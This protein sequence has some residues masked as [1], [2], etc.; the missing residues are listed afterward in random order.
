VS[1]SPSDHVPRA[2]L[3][4]LEQE[5][6]LDIEHIARTEGCSGK[7]AAERYLARRRAARG[8]RE[9]VEVTR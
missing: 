9:G 3:A 4:A 6:A 5:D 2:T 8:V 1:V 7:E